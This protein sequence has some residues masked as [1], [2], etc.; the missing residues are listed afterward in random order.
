MKPG[1]RITLNQDYSTHK[2][3]DTGTI[4]STEPPT[5][6]CPGLAYVDMDDG[7]FVCGM[8]PKRFSTT[9]ST[10]RRNLHPNRFWQCDTIVASLIVVACTAFIA[11]AI[12]YV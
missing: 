5:E 7:R 6:T 3:G 4:R 9:E 12:W 2:K 10:R 8:F 11:W 1:D